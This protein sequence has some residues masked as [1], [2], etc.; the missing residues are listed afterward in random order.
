MTNELAVKE[1][2]VVSLAYELTVDGDT[3]DQASEERPL[4]Y[5]HG[6]GN[7]IPGLEREIEGMK[8]GESRYV[9]VAAADGYGEFDQEAIIGLDRTLFA[10]PESLQLGSTVH[11]Q[12][13]A[14]QYFEARVLKVDDTT[15]T[16]DLNH[17]LAGKEL[18]FDVKIADLREPTP[19][20]I[21]MGFVPQGGCCASGGC[22]GC[23]GCG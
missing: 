21:S 11:L 18:T 8:V 5:L 14:N 4:V 22:A 19:A 20:E 16:V 17:P 15:V 12:D 6:R 7:L 1:N 3:V 9:K 2:M 13:E 10:D 23:S